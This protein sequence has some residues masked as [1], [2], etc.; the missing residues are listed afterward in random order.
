[1]RPEAEFAEDGVEEA[2][3]LAVVRLIEIE[4]YRH[5]GADVHLLDH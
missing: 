5:V 4:N 2:P 1:M 3:P